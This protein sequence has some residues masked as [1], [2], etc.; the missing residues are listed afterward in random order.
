MA[1]QNSLMATFRSTGQAIRALIVSLGRQGLFFLPFL[2]LFNHLWG[3]SGLL[4]VQ[5][6]SD[7][8]TASVAVLLGV[9]LIKKLHA[10]SK[11]EK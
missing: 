1:L 8:A 2:Y 7:L 4:Y 11:Q 9:S 6:A 5:T 10:S 3:L